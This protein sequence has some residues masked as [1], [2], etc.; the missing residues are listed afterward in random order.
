MDEKPI[1]LVVDD[2]PMILEM[3]DD[4]LSQEDFRVITAANP[5]TALSLAEAEHPEYAVLDL[6]LGWHEVSGIELGQTL[7]QKYPETMVIIMT[8]YQN[9]KYAVDAMRRFSFF[10]MI[11]P[12]RIDQVV[13]LIERAEHEH[14]LL[15]ENKLLKEKVAHLEDENVRLQQL[16]N[17][18]HEPGT[19]EKG[20]ERSRKVYSKEQV[21]RSYQQQKHQGGLDDLLKNKG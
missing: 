2:D 8:G 5:N 11:K 3:L 1:I 10:Y 6:D 16:I 17:E 18:I 4:G 12:F 21:L 20:E 14:K 19:D 15:L 7:I 13:S 9:L